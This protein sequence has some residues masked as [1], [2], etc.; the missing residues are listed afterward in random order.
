MIIQMNKK[1]K[2]LLIVIITILVSILAFC[3][4]YPLVI[5]NPPKDFKPI[6]IS[7][8]KSKPDIN[9]TLSY[10]YNVSREKHP[11]GSEANYKVRDY[12]V[13]C[14][15]EIKVQYDIQSV[16]LDEEFFIKDGK[17]I[18]ENLEDIKSKYYKYLLKKARNKNIDDLMKNE[19]NYN[20][21]DEF[22]TK[23]ILNGKSIDEQVE[24]IISENKEKYKNHTL[25]NIIVKLGSTNNENAKDI[26]LVAH[27]DSAL[28]SYGAGDDGVCVASLLETIRCTK[29]EKFK[30]NVYIVFTDG[31]ERNFWGAYEL[32]EYKGFNPS[33]FINFDNSGNSGRLV[34]YHYNNYAAVKQYFSEI[35]NECSYSFA[36]DIL[37][38]TE[39]NSPD[40]MF[41]QA[42][43][44][45]AFVF[46]KNGYNTLDFALTGNSFYYHSS[47]DNFSNID[48][49]TLNNM[50]K[51]MIEMVKY[52]GNNDILLTQKENNIHFNLLNGVV[53]SID[54][55]I[56]II[57]SIMLIIVDLIYIGILFK[58][59]K[60][61][62]KKIF[63]ILC[64]LGA[65]ITLIVFKCFSF[66]FLIPPMIMLILEF[67]KNKK[68]KEITS[69]VLYELYLFVLVQPIFM[70]IQFMLW[71]GFGH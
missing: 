30:N 63:T 19:F 2:V 40:N 27:Y 52:Y 65:I 54:K 6:E 56:Y 33:L 37:Y 64:V 8:A 53:I 28:E 62:W 44:S 11:N 69:I 15:N 58:Q 35:K 51:S 1:T 50:T 71:S 39:N 12:I 20:S 57:L 4:I 67:I 41:V 49:K 70:I 3:Q 22:Y 24:E 34:L 68:I 66:A 59:H 10:L 38:D 61:I 55:N 31:E 42:E 36:N 18:K 9:M 16:N 29:D 47:R 5:K 14:L 21:F 26:V 7:E 45:D 60:K 43:C 25:N 46:D 13:S 32:I 48:V 17:R 23:E